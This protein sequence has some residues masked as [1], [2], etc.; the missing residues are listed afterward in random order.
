MKKRKTTILGRTLAIG[1]IGILL[2]TC[3]PSTSACLTELYA[4]RN[5][6]DIGDVIVRYSGDHHLAV[7]YQTESGWTLSETN[8]AVAT[9]FDGIP[10][11][12]KGSPKVGHFPYSAD[13]PAGTTTYT[14]LVDLYDYF[15]GGG[16]SGQDLYFAAHA[17][18]NHP[19]FGEE[20]AWAD[21]WGQS[22]PG[23]SVAL[24]FVVTLP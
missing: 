7:I 18:V 16:W 23:S 12:K 15:P 4:G 6:L 1:I 3:I 24:Y 5:Q 17:V 22:F 14:Y 19:D 8:L 21:T 13:H 2:C 10:Q 20:T 9:S 11:N